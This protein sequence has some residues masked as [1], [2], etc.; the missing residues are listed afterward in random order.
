MATSPLF[1]TK[2]LNRLLHE[3]EGVGEKTTLNRTLS[4][5]NLVSL[6][7]GAIIGAGIFTLTGHAAAQYAGPAIIL[8]FLFSALGCALAGFC[9][10]EFATMIPIAGR[11]RKSV[12]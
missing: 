11:D 4:A 9:Y 1:I 3:A 6:G 8:S 12:V 2:P 10:S 5:W 7:I